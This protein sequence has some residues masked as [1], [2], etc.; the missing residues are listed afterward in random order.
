MKMKTISVIALLA[1]FSLS[2]CANNEQEIKAKQ[3]EVEVLNKK[4]D[5]I[6]SKLDE[7]NEVTDMALDKKENGEELDETQ[8]ATLHFLIG[9]SEK[10]TKTMDSI[11]NRIIDLGTEIEKLKK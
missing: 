9:E 1:I 3:K 7:I 5:Q 4:H 10:M 8:K 2:A 6:A 11:T